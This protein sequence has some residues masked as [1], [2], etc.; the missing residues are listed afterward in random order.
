[1]K[2]RDFAYWL[3]GYF[4]LNPTGGIHSTEARI[5]R[6][7]LNLVEK[8]EGELDDFGKWLAVV[9]ETIITISGSKECIKITDLVKK[10]LA[11][12][13]KHEIDPTFENLEELQKIHDGEQTVQPSQVMTPI[14]NDVRFM[15]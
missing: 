8:V 13:F 1:M 9:L 5:I 3:Q 11:E 6:N 2:H 14:D 15:C 12:K 7:H 4:E 10:R